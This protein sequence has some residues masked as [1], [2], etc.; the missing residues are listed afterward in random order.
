[1]STQLVN[2]ADGFQIWSE[3]YDRK[4]SDVF[5]VQDEIAA[6]VVAALRVK[7]LPSERAI[8][9][10]KT[11][12]QEAYNQFLLG[13]R[14]FYL[15]SP[16]GYRRANAAFEK[17]IELDP[18]YVTAYAWLSRSLAQSGYFSGSRAETAELQRGAGWAADE[19][20][21]RNP[22]LAEAVA[23]RANART[24]FSR[25][26]MGAEADFTRALSLDSGDPVTYAQYGRLL[27]R[28]GRLPEAIAQTRKATEL[29]P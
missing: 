4:A 24:L 14:F 28:R 9:S 26:W 2:V 16:D 22:A 23:A 6:A 11:S 3:T 18:G 17:A 10:Q 25:D 13:R 12:V 15:L 29:D 8:A 19:A 7:L 21:R 27:A 20:V 1:V 5:A